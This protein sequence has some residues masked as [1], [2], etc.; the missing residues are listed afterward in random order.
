MSQFEECIILI[1]SS[2]GLHVSLFR[3]AFAFLQIILGLSV[4]T[5]VGM[6]YWQAVGFTNAALI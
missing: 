1:F 6:T 5:Q 2:D 4:E 3:W